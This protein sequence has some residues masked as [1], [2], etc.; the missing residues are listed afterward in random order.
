[1]AIGVS[2]C[3]DGHVVIAYFGWD[4]PLCAQIHQKPQP[5]DGEQS[6]NDLRRSVVNDFNRLFYSHGQEGS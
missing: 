5:N 2:Y 3:K 4:C 6:V 1:M